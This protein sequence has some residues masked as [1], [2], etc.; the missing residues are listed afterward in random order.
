MKL[1]IVAILFFMPCA[2]R[3]DA[4][5]RCPQT[6]PG[7]DA[8]PVPLTGAFMD[9]GPLH[10]TGQLAPPR[11]EAAE[12]GYDLPY[13]FADDE[14]AWLICSYGARKRIKGRFHDGHEWNQRME[15]GVAEWW[16]KLAPKAGICT[17]Q[18]REAKQRSAGKSIWTVTATCQAH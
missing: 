12:E 9:A 8:P 15:G 4:V 16:M 18:V 1:L 7:N 10:G 2:A 3:A 13:A 14:Q 6:F 5:Y 17:V 11:D